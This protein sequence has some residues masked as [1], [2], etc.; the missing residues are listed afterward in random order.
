MTPEKF[1]SNILRIYQQSNFGK[2]KLSILNPVEIDSREFVQ[3]L[4]NIHNHVDFS[5]LSHVFITG[6]LLEFRPENNIVKIYFGSGVNKEAIQASANVLL[7]PVGISCLFSGMKDNYFGEHEMFRVIYSL[8]GIFNNLKDQTPPTLNT[9][10]TLMDMFNKKNFFQILKFD[11][12]CEPGF[13]KLTIE[14]KTSSRIYGP[15]FTRWIPENASMNSLAQFVLGA[16]D[17][18]NK[19]QA[20]LLRFKFN[21]KNM[22][23]LFEERS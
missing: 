1:C 17:L 21:D 13:L 18:P 5:D 20:K 4:K 23:Q 6:N 22:P 8:M 3:L 7:S 19:K 15:V 9:T 10:R 16:G 12:K 2:S 11:K 14:K